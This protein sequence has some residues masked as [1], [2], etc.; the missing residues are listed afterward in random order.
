MAVPARAP[1][2]LHM[3]GEKLLGWEELLTSLVQGIATLSL[4]RV[5]RF[6]FEFSI[7]AVSICPELVASTAFSVF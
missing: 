4:T 2:A 5:V 6:P 1:L 7:H 3:K